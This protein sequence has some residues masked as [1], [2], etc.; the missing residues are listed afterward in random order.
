MWFCDLKLAKG[1]LQ[2]FNNENVSIKCVLT[3]VFE[4]LRENFS[5]AGAVEYTDCFSAE[6]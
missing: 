2:R 3:R 1:K 5:P 6:G 4:M